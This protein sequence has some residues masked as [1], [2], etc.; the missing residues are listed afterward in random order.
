MKTALASDFRTYV[1]DCDGVILDS[2]AIKSQAF[3]DLV[4]KDFGAEAGYELQSYHRLHGGISRYKK[5]EHFLTTIRPSVCDESVISSYA[6]RYSEL[7]YSRLLTCSFVPGALD[8]ING[9]NPLTSYVVSGSDQNELRKVL[10][11]RGVASKF[12]GIYGSPQSKIEI[13]QEM[14]ERGELTYPAVFFGDA[15][16]DFEAAKALD[17]D[18]IFLYGATCWDKWSQVLPLSVRA[19][20]DFH[21]LC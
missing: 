21:A 8:F 19:V 4:A 5:I 2:N 10:R 11:E 20:Q 18:F 7:V 15:Q 16:A 3:Y 14:K 6:A 9:L 17:L 13:L 12:S 1:F